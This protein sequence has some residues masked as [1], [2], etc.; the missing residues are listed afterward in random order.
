MNIEQNNDIQPIPIEILENNEEMSTHDDVQTHE[1]GDEDIQE[2][3][4]TIFYD[5]NHHDP[6]LDDLYLDENQ[7]GTNQLDD[8]SLEE[9]EDRADYN[10]TLVR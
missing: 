6:F 9:G 1:D 3:H 7:Y 8:L 10:T 2:Q 4:G 5:H